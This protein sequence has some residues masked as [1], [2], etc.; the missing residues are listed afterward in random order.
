MGETIGIGW[1][2]GA[3]TGWGTYGVNL[4]LQLARRDIAPA[5]FLIARAPTL[6]EAQA[7]VLEPA[8]ADHRRWNDILKQ[9]AADLAFPVLHALGDKLDFPKTTAGLRGKPDI[10]IVFFESAVI[11]AA[12]LATAQRFALIVTGS[13]WNAEVLRRHGYARV[14]NCPQGIDPAVF[15][16]LPRAGKYPGRFTVFSGG[17]L[18]YR[19][20]QDLIVAA[21]K[22]FHARHDDALLVTAWHNPWPAA[23]RGLGA[24]PH[25]AGAPG[26]DGQG[27][28]DVAG[29]LRANGLPD[30]AFVDLGPLAN[31]ATPDVLRDMDLAVFPNRC[32]GGTNLVAMECM[33]MGV[34]V[35]LSRNTGHLDLMEPG[36]CY[37]LDMQIPVG[38]VTGRPAW[39]G[40]G[41]SSIDELVARMEAAYTDRAAAAKIGAAGADFM[42]G[43]DWS[44]QIAR[45]VTAVRQVS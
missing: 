13:A 17:K 10:G 44:S 28:L 45:L 36:A 3:P 11:P 42:R 38:Q 26:V 1:H 25:V 24:S 27:R 19:K 4:A 29:W 18:E 16:P 33:A 14:V 35:V 2:I 34:P 39:E 40:W 5:L 15:A 22:K 21:F 20:G 6:T 8:F 30:A 23:A 32:E 12:N 31:A 7:A 43:W 37:S 41:E 9:G